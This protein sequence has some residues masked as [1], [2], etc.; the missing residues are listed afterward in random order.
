MTTLMMNQIEGD[1][2]QL[3]AMEKFPSLISNVHILFSF[4]LLLS[5]SFN[6]ALPLLCFLSSNRFVVT[7]VFDLILRSIDLQLK[8]TMQ[9]QQQQ[10][11]QYIA[12]STSLIL[13]S[14]EVM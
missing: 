6:V 9:Q 12:I 11:Q 1:L 3:T 5:N 4:V 2:E 10:Q 14:L 8:R 7:F 13:S